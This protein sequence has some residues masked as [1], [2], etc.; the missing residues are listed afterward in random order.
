VATLFYS[1]FKSVIQQIPTAQRI[2]PA[3]VAA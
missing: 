3:E 1:R 2:I